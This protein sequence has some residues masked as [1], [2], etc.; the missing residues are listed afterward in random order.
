ML[1]VHTRCLLVKRFGIKSHQTSVLLLEENVFAEKKGLIFIFLAQDQESRDV[2]GF[3]AESKTKTFL[4]MYI[5]TK[6]IDYLQ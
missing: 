5:K 1:R 2:A 6:C 4:K 3:L